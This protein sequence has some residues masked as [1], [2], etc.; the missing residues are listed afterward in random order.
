MAGGLIA[1]ISEGKKKLF[2]FFFST[3]RKEGTF[4]LEA[5]SK[6]VGE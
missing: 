5:L 4:V 1:M 2:F 3:P 6:V